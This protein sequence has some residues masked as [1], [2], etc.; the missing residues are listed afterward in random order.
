[1]SCVPLARSSVIW[2]LTSSPS[3][4]AMRGASPMVSAS[5]FSAAAQPR[6]LI[7]PALAITLMP[8]C[9]TCGNTCFI[10]V[11]TKSVA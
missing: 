3:T 8:R 6:G 9:M 2:A 4:T 1:M 7:P 5:A 11:S 10:A